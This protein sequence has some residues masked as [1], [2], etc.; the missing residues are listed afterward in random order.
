MALTL[1]VATVSEPRLRLYRLSDGGCLFLEIHP[2]GGKYWRFKCRFKGQAN[3]VSCGVFPTV[4]IENARTRRDAFRAMLADGVD[5]S[6]HIKAERAKQAE[7]T[8]QLAATR[9][10]L[11]SNGALSFHLVSRRLTLT[12][13]ETTELRTFL[14]ATRAVTPKVT[15]C[16]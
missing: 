1:D 7:K 11:D 9:F 14:D 4:S 12:T 10:A 13:A 5:P 2:T 6:E 15:P 16:P 8:R 3:T